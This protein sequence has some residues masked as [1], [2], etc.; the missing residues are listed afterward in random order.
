MPGFYGALPEEDIWSIVDYIVSLS[1]N[2]VEA[3][4][5]SLV[6][7]R[8]TREALD[9][10]AG[11]E[12]FADAPKTT[13][14]IVGQIIEPGRNFHPSIVAVSVQ[15]VH[16]HKEIAFHLSWHDM[17]AETSG[18]N[19]PDI[20]APLWDDELAALGLVPE[21]TSG[22]EGGFWGDEAEDDSG[23]FWGEEEASDDEGDFWGDDAVAE[24]D[25]GTFWGD[26]V[27]ADDD[28]GDFWGDDAVA[29]DSDEDFW[30]ADDDSEPTAALTPDTEFTDAVA[31]QFPLEMPGGIRLPYFMFG[32]TQN[33]VQIWHTDLGTSAATVWTGRGS[34]ALSPGDG[35]P[36]A[37]S[38]SYDSGEW[39][40][41]MKRARRTT[42]GL[43]FEEAKFIPVALSVWDGFN[44]ER[45]NRRGLTPWY[46][47]YLEPLEK[48]SSVRPMLKAGLGV[49]GLELLIIG[50]VRL[51]ARKKS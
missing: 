29:D 19:A 2:T 42:T 11:A 14:P 27:A 33:A 6:Q 37:I 5:G 40:V 35:E 25:E 47:L 8:G 46:Y 3:P 10:A 21:E 45:G 30:G 7:S 12:L 43:E 44:R 36:P 9:L 13:L 41:I 28:S 18:S 31:L 16:N 23:G 4:Y 48:P 24:E 38:V 15:A 49:L 51:R 20:S 32:D 26:E 1:G 50:L 17:R 39:S 22:A 34:A